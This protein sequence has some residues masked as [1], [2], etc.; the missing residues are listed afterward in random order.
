MKKS[1][2]EIANEID[3]AKSWEDVERILKENEIGRQ[4]FGDRLLELCDAY[5]M[6][7]GKLQVEVLE[8]SVSKS[9]FYAAINGTRNPSAEIVIR[10][11][12]VL[13]TTIEELNEL[14][15]L[16]KHKELYSKTIEGNV[17]AF[18][19]KNKKSIYEIDDTLKSYNSKLRLLDEK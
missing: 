7:P 6:K 10:I 9:Q 11:A 4:T 18:G 14:L 3:N 19:I 15:K 16:A 13:G 1:T 12:L 5:K 8:V 2:E 17:I